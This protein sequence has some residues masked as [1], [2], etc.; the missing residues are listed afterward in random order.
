MEIPD[1]AG[2]N[3]IGGEVAAPWL[4]RRGTAGSQATL[5]CTFDNPGHRLA[6]HFALTADILRSTRVILAYRALLAAQLHSR[7]SRWAQ[8]KIG[9]AARCN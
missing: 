4:V 6:A 2:T 9:W 1:G 8:M 3:A 5:H 7:T